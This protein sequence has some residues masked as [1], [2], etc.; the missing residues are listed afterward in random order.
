MNSK[1]NWLR[2][3]FVK[4]DIQGMIVSNPTN[5]RYLTNIDAE[6][7]LLITRK[8]NYYLTDGRYVETVKK[9]LTIEDEIVVCDVKELVKEDYQNFFMLC[10]NV[11][12]EGEYVTYSKYKDI[13]VRYKVI[14]LVETEGIIESQ[15]MIKDREEIEK[16]RKACEITDKCFTYLTT[17]I[18]RGMTEK[19]IA[20]EV[21]KY[22]KLNGADDIAFETIVA[23]RTKFF[24]ATCCSN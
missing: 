9:I 6:G 4:L 7:T 11:G 21:M 13:M 12:F 18:K 5:I 16:I 10:Q 15:R 17:F 22:F 20:I 1:I 14:N 24:Y 2:E 23:S 19:E 3:Q 8:E